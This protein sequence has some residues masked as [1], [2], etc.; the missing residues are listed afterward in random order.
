MA[1]KREE[2]EKGER[3]APLVI[4][5]KRRRR[6][7]KGVW[8][9][10]LFPPPSILSPPP[11]SFCP[12]PFKGPFRRHPHSPFPL[13]R[14][15]RRKRLRLI[16]PG[17]GGGSKTGRKEAEADGIVPCRVGGEIGS[18]RVCLGR[19][20]KK[21]KFLHAEHQVGVGGKVA[22]LP[23]RSVDP[24]P[25][26]CRHRQSSSPNEIRCDA[27]AGARVRER[28]REWA[29]KGVRKEAP[30]GSPL[31]L[32]PSDGGGETQRRGKA[33]K[34]ERKQS[35]KK[36]SERCGLRCGMC[37]TPSPW[38]T[39]SSSTSGHTGPTARGSSAPAL[40][41]SSECWPPL[42]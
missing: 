42:G 3:G 19:R 23:S 10:I 4:S 9:A 18:A 6:G 29:Q 27:W 17:G 14:Q 36:E 40:G 32:L 39:S 38:R 35:P 16:S 41:F 30:L 15:R 31:L 12:P 34:G 13:S 24:P 20:R 37:S 22:P 33:E 11:A 2:E 28:E 8:P 25:V 21:K 7:R 5:E 1:R 26:G